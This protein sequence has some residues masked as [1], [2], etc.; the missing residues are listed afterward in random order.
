MPRYLYKEFSYICKNNHITKSWEWSS[1]SSINC[2]TCKLK[3]YPIY[4]TRNRNAQ[5][6]KPPI[7][8]YN[9]TT[10]EYRHLSSEK[11][12]VPHGFNRVELRTRSEIQ[13]CCKSMDSIDKKQHDARIIREQL[14]AQL[15][16][17]P[18][19]D[20]KPQTEL[21]AQLE[22]YARELSKREYTPS[23]D[24]SNYIEVFENNRSN[25]D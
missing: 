9:P 12:R 11:S 6:F 13:A 7:V 23:Y 14:S 21:G 3:S 5:D 1:T 15:R 16:E 18:L 25:L 24:P 10:K 2:T 8:A 22:E 19:H 4:Q 17:D 20:Y